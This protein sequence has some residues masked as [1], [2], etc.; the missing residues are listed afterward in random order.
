M[1]SSNSSPSVS[2]EAFRSNSSP[3]GSGVLSA[4]QLVRESADET[5]RRGRPLPIVP[6]PT[7]Y[8]SS[9]TRVGD[10]YCISFDN[11]ARFEVCFARKL[12]TIFDVGADTTSE[13]LTHLLYDHVA[14]RILAGAGELIIH[15]SAVA[16]GGRLAVFL[17]E[18]GAGKSTLAASLHNAGHRLVGDDAAILAPSPDG[19]CGRSVYP[20]LRLYPE[21]I[22]AV[23]GE[24]VS[25]APMAHY[26]DKKRLSLPAL[27]DADLSPIPL[28]GFFF[29]VDDDG[30]GQVGSRTL[31][32]GHTCIGLIENSF[33][34]DK[35]DADAAAKR[36]EKISHIARE[37]PGY[38]LSYPWDFNVLPKVHKEI[39]ARIQGRA[40]QNGESQAVSSSG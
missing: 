23:L 38:E 11:V 17:G 31:S 21:S 15:A 28:G 24:D 12:V 30:D 22:A 7:E 13:A 18:T 25:S 19:F 9:I 5:K 36:M 4:W 8:P 2:E 1:T 39:L 32:P 10:P 14:P 26:S 40:D 6:N 16:I 34:L 37:V 29:L 35:D 27:D 20:S 3:F 33:A